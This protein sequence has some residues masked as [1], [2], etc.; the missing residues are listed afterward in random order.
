M[1]GEAVQVEQ[2][3]FFTIGEGGNRNPV[4]VKFFNPVSLQY[5]VSNTLAQQ[6]KE[7]QQYVSQSSAKLTMDLVFDTT[8]NG[9]DVRQLTCKIAALMEPKRSVSQTDAQR[10][11]PDI[12]VFEWG[13]FSFQGMVESYKETIDFFAPEGVPL[14]ATVNLTMFRQ[15]RVF[16]ADPRSGSRAHAEPRDVSLAGGQDLTR[17]GSKIGSAG[18][19]SA[20]DMMR[21][22][23]A[24]N[25]VENPRNALATAVTIA[26]V[27]PAVNRGVSATVGIGLSV[28]EPALSMRVGGSL[29]AGVAASA[30]AFAGLRAPT[31]SASA[32][33]DLDRLTPPELG[34]I[35][36][37]A[38]AQ[39]RL[40]GQAEEQAGGGS[41][42]AN[43]G[44][45]ASLSSELLFEE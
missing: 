11:A 32:R 6:E 31:A 40:G 7:K 13:A 39:F 5:S 12:V 35:S 3:K 21:R 2:A 34:R 9:T 24:S 10:K 45:E 23:A 26:G 8:H 1:S 36:T 14:R 41:F 20:A 16:E 17:L 43:V 42:A 19:L 37:G 44:A 22:I 33:V 15:D 18:H 4:E 38:K 28:G 29:S 27:L 30:G 25:G